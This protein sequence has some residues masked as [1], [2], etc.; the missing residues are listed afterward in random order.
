MEQ[1]ALEIVALL[2][3]RRAENR[4]EVRRRMVDRGAKFSG[5]VLLP[6]GG[7][8]GLRVYERLFE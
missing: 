2:R 4:I 1:I 7:L 5:G 8:L 3:R 6:Q